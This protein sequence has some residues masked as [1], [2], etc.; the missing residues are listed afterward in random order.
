MRCLARL[1]GLGGLV[2]LGMSD[3]VGR[4]RVA[5]LAGENRGARPDQEC[6]EQK[7]QDRGEPD[8]SAAALSADQSTVHRTPCLAW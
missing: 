3:V 5:V 4:V 7:R 6:L 8:S 2:M 1:G